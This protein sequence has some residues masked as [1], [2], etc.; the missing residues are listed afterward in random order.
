MRVFACLTHVNSSHSQLWLAPKCD[1]ATV[2]E[3]AAT[4]F[5]NKSGDGDPAWLAGGAFAR[6]GP[7]RQQGA[8]SNETHGTA[9]VQL[10]A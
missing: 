8:D 7:A 1:V 6:E 2:V 10:G 5:S 9:P 4:A 3:W